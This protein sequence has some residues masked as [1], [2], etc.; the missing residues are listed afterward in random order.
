M[1]RRSGMNKGDETTVEER[2]LER[3]CTFAME[4]SARALI[5]RKVDVAG[6]VERTNYLES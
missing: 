4:T 1:R 3:E 2:S 6:D 5:W